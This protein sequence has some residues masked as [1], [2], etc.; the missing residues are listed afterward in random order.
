MYNYTQIDPEKC[1]F[2]SVAAVE[3]LPSGDRL[4]IEVDDQEIVLFNVAGVY[5][6]ILDVCSH[7]DGPLGDGDLDGYEVSCPRHGAHFDIRTG[8]ALSLPAVVDIPA[9]PTR[10]KDGQIEIGLPAG[11]G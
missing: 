3:E 4:F 11:G 2:L 1:E 10:V 7:D 6:A 9:F 8:E 5:Y